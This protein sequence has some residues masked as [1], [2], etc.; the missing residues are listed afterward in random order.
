VALKSWLKLVSEA[1]LPVHQPGARGAAPHRAALS[2]AAAGA[3]DGVP[4]GAPRR[5]SRGA[6]AARL[7]LRHRG[8]GNPYF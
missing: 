4:D 7:A 8:R 5:G 1:L 3:A 6:D 2:G